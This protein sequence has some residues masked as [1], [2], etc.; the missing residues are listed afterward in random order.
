[1]NALFSIS[2][3]SGPVNEIEMLQLSTWEWFLLLAF[4]VIL[5]WLLIMFQ[6]MS[7]KSSEYISNTHDHND[8][9]TINHK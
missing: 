3:E 6:V 4:V 1:M 7:T 9:P 5:A 8:D 2:K